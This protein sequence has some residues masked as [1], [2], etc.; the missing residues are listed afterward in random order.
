[1]AKVKRSNLTARAATVAVSVIAGL[2]IWFA[3]ARPLQTATTNAAFTPP[4]TPTA[5]PSFGAN[6]SFLTQ[7]PPQ[8]ATGVSGQYAAPQAPTT[9]LRTR[10]S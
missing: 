6:D 2:G 5:D 10:A 7:S 4:G 8:S 9:R 3:V 1:M